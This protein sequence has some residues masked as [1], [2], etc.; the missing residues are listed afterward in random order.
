M[1]AVCEDAGKHMTAPAYER[2]LRQ[3]RMQGKGTTSSNL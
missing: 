1:R 3:L 2:I